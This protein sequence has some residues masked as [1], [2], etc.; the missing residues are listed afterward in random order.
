M[1]ASITHIPSLHKIL[2]TAQTVHLAQT[3]L[4]LSLARDR[5]YTLSPPAL[6]HDDHAH[7][8]HFPAQPNENHNTVVHHWHVPGTAMQIIADLHTTAC[9]QLRN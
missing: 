8:R 1:F 6:A 2:S 9:T 7:C 4:Q 5:S 3:A